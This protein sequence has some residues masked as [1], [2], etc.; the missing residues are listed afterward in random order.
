[1]SNVN[2]S[3]LDKNGLTYLWSQLK[4]KFATAAQGTKA[5]TAVQT[6]KINNTAQTKT[7]G[8]VNLPAYPTKS[9]LGLGNVDNTS[10][11]NKPIST[12][13]AND[14][15]RQDNVIAYNAECGVKNAFRFDKVGVSAGAAERSVTRYGV[16]FTVNNDGSLTV[17]RQS[18]NSNNSTIYFYVDGAAFHADKFCNGSFRFT[19]GIE[20]ST[21]TMYFSFGK[22]DSGSAM[23]MTENQVI[24]SRRSN[25]DIWVSLTVKSSYSPS[26]VVLRPMIRPECSDATFAKN[27]MTNA[28]LSEQK[29]DLLGAFGL[30]IE[31]TADNSDFDT[32]K[33][34]GRYFIGSSVAASH[35]TNNCPTNKYNLQTSSTAPSDW[36]TDYYKFYYTKDDS[37]GVYTILP[38]Q[39]S[40]PT[41]EPNV[42][43][44]RIAYGG[45]L[46]VEY[47]QNTSRVRQTYYVN[48]T[49]GDAG[50]YY[51]R[52]YVSGNTWSNWYRINGIGAIGVWL[53]SGVDIKSLG[54]GLYYRDGTATTLV[55][56]PSDWAFSTIVIQVECTILSTRKRITIYPGSGTLNPLADCFYI[57]TQNS[58]GWS[59]WIKFQGTA[60][61]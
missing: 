22:L 20:T 15:T 12:A 45:E 48:N 60:V 11:A 17:D 58:T 13:V 43:Y 44:K 53:A 56:L 41:Y 6:I 42:Y 37:T 61:T 21:S 52:M 34:P 27:I 19:S 9:S 57:A 5:D 36:S 31:I 40:A 55:G 29:I 50:Y 54:P 25:A 26:N 49:A 24:P 28:E 23:A 1:M 38:Q 18:A 16:K 8:M 35:D 10:D 14:Q 32:F 30:G 4:L 33:T 2:G 46:I 51:T 47:V 59:P 7:D 3:F 39:S